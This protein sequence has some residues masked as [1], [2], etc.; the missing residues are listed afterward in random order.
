MDTLL[1]LGLTVW[2]SNPP[3]DGLPGL[4]LKTWDG[5]WGGTWHH[6]EASIGMKHSCE[7]IMTVGCT[8]LNFDHYAPNAK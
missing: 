2:V 5:V 6:Q 3:P 1:K 4:D 7:A 8:N